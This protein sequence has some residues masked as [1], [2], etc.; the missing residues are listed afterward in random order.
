MLYL[1]GR[2]SQSALE[3][4]KAQVHTCAETKARG[5]VVKYW[6]QR[7]L[8]TII[9]EI[10]ADV[11]SAPIYNRDILLLEALSPTCW[12]TV[13][14]DLDFKG[15]HGRCRAWR[16]ALL[17]WEVNYELGWPR[18]TFLLVRR[19]LNHFEILWRN[20]SGC[21]FLS[22]QRI[23]R[24][25]MFRNRSSIRQKQKKTNKRPCLKLN[26]IYKCRY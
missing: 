16:A 10:Y 13:Q 12:T 24:R 8:N 11:K 4:R 6:Y 18:M 17:L 14:V 5:R 19:F 2:R 25:W 21:V 20:V 7:L 23:C 3:I 9:C 1:H 15:R 26:E 22:F